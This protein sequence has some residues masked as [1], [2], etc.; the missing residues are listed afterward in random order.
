[1]TVDTEIQLF[2][3]SQIENQTTHLTELINGLKRQITASNERCE[4]SNE[5][6]EL[7]TKENVLLKQQ[8]VE[9]RV[10]IDRLNDVVTTNRKLSVDELA[11]H[12]AESAAAIKAAVMA[13]DATIDGLRIQIDDLE[14]YGRRKSI[15]V[16]NVPV[17]A[18]E[19]KDRSQNLLLTSIN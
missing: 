7:L 18:G 10:E 9:A 15:R 13:S 1:M 2:I 4:R 16:Q 11:Q 12:K 14:Q 19:D 5:R 3:S 8:L 6:C 17:V